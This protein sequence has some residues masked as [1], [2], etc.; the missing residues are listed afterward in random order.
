MLLKCLSGGWEDAH[1]YV[2]N[3][4]SAEKGKRKVKKHGKEKSKQKKKDYGIDYG[5]DI[6][7]GPAETVQNEVKTGHVKKDKWED[8]LKKRHGAH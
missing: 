4:Q 2:R 7:Y 8:T 6:I 5:V 3:K 1:E